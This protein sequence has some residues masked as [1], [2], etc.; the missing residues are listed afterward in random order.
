MSPARFSPWKIVLAT[1]MLLYSL[2]HID[3]IFGFGAPEPLA[4][5]YSRS[6]YRVT[7][8][9]TALDAGFAT[10]MN[11]KPKWLRDIL[12]VV[13]S[14]YYIVYANEADE[15][16]RKYRALCTVEMLRCTWEKTTNPYLRMATWFHRPS[17]PI[18]RPILLPRPIVGPHAKRPIQAWLFYANGKE[19]DL[20]KEEEVS[21]PET[22]CA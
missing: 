20:A 13:F 6:F 16:L 3:S 21:T 4:L 7:W 2:R 5:M 17:L 1:L 11:V 12:S 15:K 9:V 19:A 8:I 22:W 10:A 14:F 18:A